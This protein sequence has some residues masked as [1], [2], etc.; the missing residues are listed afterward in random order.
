MSIYITGDT[1]GQHDW[2]KLNT[3]NFPA[4]KTM[5]KDD[6]VI[7]AGD[8]GGVWDG[9]GSDR[10]TQEWY[11][12]KN[13]T[14]A[15]VDGNH[16]NHWL[17]NSYPVSKWNGGRVHRIGQKLIHLMRGEIYTIQGKTFFVMGGA[18]SVDKAYRKYGLSWW[19]EELPSDKE[20]KT[21]LRKAQSYCD[22]MHMSYSRLYDQLTSE[23]GEQYSADAAQYA[24][25]NVDTDWNE[26][27]LLMA[28][29]YQDSLDM[30]PAAIYD[31][32]VSSYGEGFTPEQAQY[33]IDNL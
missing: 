20:Y 27:A 28:K 32:L 18:D 19:P 24:V 12:E 6:L 13:H 16:E 2:S 8:F 11:N 9:A 1:H 3:E 33:A 17:L 31:Q 15:F 10:Y 22:N 21:A 26:N 5:T 29:S 4:Q 7:I 30:S 25:D 23:Y 14:T